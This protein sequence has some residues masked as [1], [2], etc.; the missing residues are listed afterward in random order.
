LAESGWAIARLENLTLAQTGEWSII[1]EAAGLSPALAYIT[2]EEPGDPLCPPPNTHAPEITLDL[3]GDDLLAEGSVTRRLPGA[4]LDVTIER[5]TA[6]PLP[7]DLAGEITLAEL[8]LEPDAEHPL[9][10]TARQRD[11]SR[12]WTSALF[13]A[14]AAPRTRS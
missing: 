9:F 5:I 7:R 2:V 12:I 1:A 14:P 6:A 13:L 10:I 11:Q 8:N 4:E 3:S